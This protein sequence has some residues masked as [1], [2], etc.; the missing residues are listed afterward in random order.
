MQL[1]SRILDLVTKSLDGK[2]AGV[3]LR[4]LNLVLPQAIP[5]NRPLGLK[6]R[7]LDI[8]RCEVELPF[9][10]ATKNH[11][12]GLHACALATVG[13]YSAGV[14]I[15]RRM[16]SSRQRL[17]LKNLE[18]DFLKQ[19]RGTAGATAEWPADATQNVE[20]FRRLENAVELRMVS[21]LRSREGT[22]LAHVRTHWQIKPWSKVKAK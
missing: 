15:L 2:N 22:E 14:L 9:K 3:A 6:I 1:G 19:G 20:E 8:S 10:R 4:F 21:T 16:D 17:V 11:L 7:K 13:E 18:V 5:F 12:G